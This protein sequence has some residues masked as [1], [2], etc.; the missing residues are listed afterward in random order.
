[1]NWYKIF[2]WLTVADNARDFFIVFTIIFTVTFVIS[3]LFFIFGRD[4]D[5]FQITKTG[6]L[7]QKWVWYSTPLMLL[8]WILLIGTPKKN[9]TLLIIA[10][11]A[12]G[13]FITTDTNSTAIPAEITK[14][15]RLKLQEE[16]IG[17][18]LEVKK[19]FGL[20]T[21]K[22]RF[23]NEVKNLTKEEILRKIETD[24]TFF[25]K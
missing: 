9:D 23:I 19:A 20:E 10:G 1:M 8:F 21:P 14:F 11:G 13:N 24:S 17:S 6:I 18:E 12:V 22:E 7:A 25:N 5:D 15:I 2:Y 3:I 16:I 4:G